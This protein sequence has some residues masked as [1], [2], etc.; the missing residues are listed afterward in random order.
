MLKN[1]FGDYTLQFT[2]SQLLGHRLPF[3]PVKNLGC[4]GKCMVFLCGYFVV[5][6]RSRKQFVF[7]ACDAGNASMVKMKVL[8]IKFRCIHHI[9]RYIEN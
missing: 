1:Y 6:L 3:N 8:T 5:G 2:K 7:S 9:Y 4:M